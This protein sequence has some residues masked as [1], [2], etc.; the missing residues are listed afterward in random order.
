MK[1]ELRDFLAEGLKHYKQASHV[2]T[3]F[4]RNTQDELQGILKKRKDWGSAFKPQEAIRV[5]STKYWDEYPLINAQIEG[6]VAGKP[7]TIR[8]S[9]NWF[10]SESEYPFYEVWF[11]DGPAS[12]YEKI[13]A[14][15]KRGRVVLSKENRGLK[16]YPDPNDFNLERDF[17]ILIDEFARTISK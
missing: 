16:M 12:V 9:I 8:I 3:E 13:G 6:Y 11:Y 5:R 7:A 4:F 10:E 15:K 14:Y 17:T 1:N 2:M